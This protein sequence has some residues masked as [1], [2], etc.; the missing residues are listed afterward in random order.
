M[1]RWPRPGDRGPLPL[2]LWLPKTGMSGPDVDLRWHAFLRR[3]DLEHTFRFEEQTLGWTRPELRTPEAADRWTWLVIAAHTQLRLI[4]E[5]AADLR[6]P[7]EKPA[8]PA[9]L[10]PARV[11][12]SFRNIRPTCTAPPVHRNPRLP[13]RAAGRLE[14][15]AAGHPIRRGQNNQTAREHR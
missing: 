14:E 7:W 12:R 10:T 9:G 6:R 1:T 15:P 2:W 8:E 4:R 3:S 5:A 13:P 11:R